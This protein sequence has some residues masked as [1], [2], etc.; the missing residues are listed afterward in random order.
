[1]LDCSN[2][3]RIVT[4]VDEIGIGDCLYV[5]RTGRTHWV[6]DMSPERVLLEDIDGKEIPWVPDTLEKAFN[7]HPWIRQTES[8]AR[9]KELNDQ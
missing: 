5:E 4:S 7:A 2:S 1:M 9:K 3:D 6:V 8:F